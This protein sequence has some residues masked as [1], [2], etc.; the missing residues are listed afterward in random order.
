MTPQEFVAK[1]QRV[2]LSERSACQQHFCDLCDLLGQPKPA[3]ADPDGSWYT[4]EK[5]VKKIEGGQGWADVWMRGHFGW[6]YKGRHK[7]LKEAYQQL[8]LYREALENPCLLV[9]CDMDRFEVHTNFPNTAKRVYEFNLDGLAKPANLDVLRKVFTEPEAL[10]PDLTTAKITEEAADRFADLAQRLRMR[11]KGTGP[12]CRNGPQG[13]AH[14]LDLS[15]FPPDQRIAHFLMKMMFCMFG[16]DI[17]LLPGKL[18]AKVLD[19]GKRNPAALTRRLEGLFAAMS[20]GGDFGSDEIPWFNGGLFADSDVIALTAEEINILANVN[21]YDWASVEP[22]IFGTLFEGALDPDKRSQIG[23][24]YTDRKDIE[25]LVR[26]VVM[27]PLRREWDEVK[28]QCEEKLWPAV[29]KAARATPRRAAKPSAARAKFD[30]AIQDFVERLAHVTVLDPACGSGNFLYVALNLLLDLEKEV[31]SYAAAH[32]LSLVPQVH[33]RQLA[34]LEIN[35]FAQQLASVVLW[36][37][38][39]QWMHHNG[40]KMPSHPV[41][42]PI[43]T[44]R[45]QDAILDLSDAEHPKEP[46]WPPA[47]FI[48]G[49]PPFLGNKRMRSQL[50]S[51]YVRQLWDLYGDRLPATSDLCCYWFEKGR[52]MADTGNA[53]RVGL[54]ATSVIKQVGAQEVLTRIVRTC[55][56]FFAISDRPWILEGASLR[57]SM[58]GFGR[59]TADEPIVLDGK[60]VPIIRANLSTG[61]DVTAKRELTGNRGLCFMGVTKVGDFDIDFACARDFLTLPNASGRP[62]SDVLRPFR[63][64]SDIVRVPTDRWIIDFGCDLPLEDATRYE[65]PFEYLKRHVY[66][67][68]QRNNRAAYRQKW[69]IH[70]E[71]RPGFRAMVEPLRRYIATARVA[72]HRI[73][74]WFESVVLPDSKVI[75]IAL[76]SECT[77]A[78]LQ[79]RVHQVWT[80]AT[81]GWHGGERQTYNPTLCFETFPFPECLGGLARPVQST[82]RG[83]RSAG[84][85]MVEQNPTLAAIAAAARELDDLRK[86]WLNPPEWTTTEVLE[87]PG[88]VAGPWAR[89]VVDPDKRG[90]GTVRWPRVVP[91]DPDCAESLRKRTLTNLYNQRPEWLR[92]AHEKLDAAVFAAYG[93]ESGISDEALLEKL[94]ALNLERAAQSVSA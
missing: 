89:Y 1:W 64:G 9:V 70:A 76:S 71:A 27:A 34:G 10:R 48:V 6:E 46:E 92:L 32:G 39:L 58:V 2:T 61:C 31:I 63:N 82:E 25:T 16:E 5:G 84:S 36:I 47:E 17:G 55:P 11:E 94:L 15:P 49:N 12:I 78:I 53:S 44:I 62:N 7:D 42:E 56:I 91:K 20:T 57:I 73:F 19:P 38:Y 87:F 29:V 77:F 4:F 21:D 13:A 93:W 23:A 59:V 65:G 85:E 14:K 81:C 79:S 8:C 52:D 66:E 33:P 72:R 18:F 74:V 88:S 3:E 24:H 83:I 40:F 28:R 30:R 90:I 37:G 69:W 80:R 68:R 26:P 51:D 43:E 75:A 35:P 45:C 67:D 54:L 41:L 50:G 22:S 60:S 86:A